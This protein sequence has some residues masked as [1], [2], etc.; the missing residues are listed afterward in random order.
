MSA[1][2]RRWRALAA[3]AA[4]AAMVGGAA[5]ISTTTAAWVDRT[6]FHAEASSLET[7]TPAAETSH[8]PIAM[9]PGLEFSVLQQPTQ[10]PND[11]DVCVQR[12]SVTNTTA[13][14]LEWWVEFDV[15][16]PPLW[17]LDPTVPGAFSFDRIRT[18]SFDAGTGVWRIGG[19]EADTQIVQPGASIGGI[20]YCTTTSGPQLPDDPALY[21]VEVSR[22]PLGVQS[23]VSIHVATTFPWAIVWSTRVDMLDYY[24]DA[25]LA[26]R[27][28][29]TASQAVATP[30]AGDPYVFDVVGDDSSRM[31][32]APWGDRDL[33]RA[34][35][36]QPPTAPD[37]P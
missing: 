28:E 6:T 13:E 15:D 37:A 23:C 25:E 17:G 12:M 36:L 3:F 22:A 31:I 34:V 4:M 21:E 35:C 11:A 27:T 9:S 18:I 30:V 24:T 19:I 14:P 20:G 32:A 26:G 16:L 29:L 10:A 8:D 5:S 1:R 7:F 33:V 2:V